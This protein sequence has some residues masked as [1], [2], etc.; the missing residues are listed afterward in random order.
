[1]KGS[2]TGRV[3]FAGDATDPVGITLM[4]TAT[5]A[6]T[7]PLTHSVQLS[8]AASTSPVVGYNTYWSEISG[9]PYTNLTNTPDPSLTYT[10][11]SVQPGTYYFVVTSIDS[12]N[13][14]SPYSSEVSALVP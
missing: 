8:W 3:T 14:E 1:M 12:T 7:A 2:E 13:N 6:S 9:G 4:G 5:S 11:A 10:D